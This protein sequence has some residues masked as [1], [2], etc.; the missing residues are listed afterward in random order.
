MT[1]PRLILA[2]NS[3]RRRQILAWTGWAFEMDAADLN[4][5]PLPGEPPA[6]YVSRLAAEKARAVAE[7]YRG[8][9]VIVLAA[10]TT[11]A[12]GAELLGKPGDA[13]EAR[14]MLRRLRG[15]T[16]Q[17]YTALALMDVQRAGLVQDLCVSQV[18]MREYTD[19]EI[20]AYILSGD[21]F[22]K[23]GGYAIQHPGFRPVVHFKGCFASVMGLPLC[24]LQRMAARL[25]LHPPQDVPQTC[26][27]NLQYP[28][29]IWQAVL[30]GEA[31]G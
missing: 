17:V 2:S 25:N 19:E 24:H 14:S 23:A 1:Q 9:A 6:A 27:S 13:A 4:E 12:D 20:E 26:Q 5:D 22:D 3:P 15:R 30:N 29:P 28:C 10:D 16:H 18:P 31:L 21:P 11:V 8:Q 7:K